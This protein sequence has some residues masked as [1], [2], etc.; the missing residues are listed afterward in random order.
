M[1][2][3]QTL[4]ARDP[5]VTFE[6]RST[7]TRTYGQRNVL[8]YRRCYCYTPEKVMATPDQNCHAILAD[9][10]SKSTKSIKLNKET[11]QH[12]Q[13]LVYVELFPCLF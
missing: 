7:L 12:K 13:D 2:C 4:I 9:S 3:A 8:A 10:A 6:H 1:F 5:V 11:A